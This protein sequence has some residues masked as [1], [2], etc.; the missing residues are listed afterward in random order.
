MSFAEVSSFQGVGIDVI[1]V[2]IVILRE[3]DFLFE[4]VYTLHVIMVLNILELYKFG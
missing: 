4:H 2:L 1:S 3:F